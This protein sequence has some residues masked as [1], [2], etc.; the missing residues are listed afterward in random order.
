[1]GYFSDLG[2]YGLGFRIMGDR[3]FW[4]M[5]DQRSRLNV[6]VRGEI[7]SVAAKAAFYWG[8]GGGRGMPVWQPAG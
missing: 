3:G 8:S 1:M 4:L 5:T 7:R 6:V 2:S